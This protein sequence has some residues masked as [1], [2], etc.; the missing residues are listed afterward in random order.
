MTGSAKGRQ[1]P[2]RPATDIVHAGRDPFAHH[3]F[4]NPPV[5]RGSTV[6]FKTLESFEKRDQRYVYGRR[7][8]PTSEALEAAI[9]RLEG[10]VR[11]WLAPSGAAAI[12]T[13]LV[14]FLKAGDHILVADTVYLPTRKICD[15]PLQRFGVET[16]YYDPTLGADIAGLMRPNTTLVYTESPGSLTFEVQDIPAIAAAAHAAGALVAMDNTWAS[17]LYFKPFEHGVDIAI[18]AGTKYIV[19]HADAMLGA[20]TVTEPLAPRLVAEA[21]G[22]GICAGTEEMYLGLRGFRTLDVRLERH[23]RSS[24][25]IARWLEGRPEVARVRHPALPSHPQ[26]ELWKRDF[27][28]ASGLFSIELK[29]C[30]RHAVASMIE[31]LELFGIGA[32]WGG[33][34]SLVLPF[35]A[36]KARSATAW[37]PEGPTV[38]LHIGLEDVA[39]LRADLEAGFARLAAAGG[40]AG[41]APANAPRA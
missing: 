6:L 17:P 10:G 41:D 18:Q 21:G 38:R 2:R 25:E 33:Y 40:M 37:Q 4:V 23:W 22:L 35:D 16:T 9:A 20:V 28:G 32:S 26:H 34:E 13:A 1:P 39:D 3:G 19:G 12:A 30:P 11:A 14:S 7:G 31:G 5:Y 8:T 27:L 15:G 29:P 36:A 24:L